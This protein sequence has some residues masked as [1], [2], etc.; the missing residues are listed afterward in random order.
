MKKFFQNVPVLLLTILLTGIIQLNAQT[1]NQVIEFCTG[2]W[3]QWCP[4]GDITI[5]NLL[6]DHPNLIPLAY[7]G[8][9]GSDPY[10]NFP[11]NEIISLLGFTGYPTG[12]VDRVSSPG[13]YTTWT[14]K[15]NSRANIP[16][17][18]SIELQRSYNQA[19]GHLDATIDMTA[20][21]N[22]SGTF[23]YNIILTED[24][25]I[26]DQV[27]NGVCVGGGNDW[28]H[29]WVVRAMINGSSG[30]VIVDN[31]DWNSGEIITKQVTYDVP[32]TF[33]A[34]QCHLVVFVY[35]QNSP[36][37]MAEIQQAEKWSLISPNYVV[38]LV[39]PGSDLIVNNSSSADFT[40]LIR[41]DGLLDDSYYIDIEMSSP[42]G[43]TGEYTTP[44]GTLPFG[45]QD[46]VFVSAGDSLTVDLS[47]FPNSI[48]GFGEV[49]VKF[50]SMND[51]NVFAVQRFR[52][53][54]ESG[55]AGLVIDASAAGY[56]ELLLNI[57]DQ[58]FDYPYGIVSREALN[59]S[60]D[61]TNFT[62]I[63][64]SSGNQYPVLT[65]DEVNALIPFLENGGRLLI[66]GQ[67]IGQDIFDPAGLSQA[68]QS[69]YNNYLHANYVSGWG[70]S[71][72]LNGIAGDPISNQI[73]FPLGDVYPKDPDEFIPMDA[74]ATSLFKFG[75][76]DRFNS[77]KAD[78]GINRVVYFGFGFEQ[79]GDQSI[80][81]TLIAR[82]LRW[83][84]EGVVVSTP[85]DEIKLNTFNLYQNYP[86]PF[87]PATTIQYSVGETEF[88][89]IS[90]YDLLGN[91]IANLVNEVKQPGTYNLTFDASELSSGLY[92]YKLTAGDFVSVKKMT[93]LK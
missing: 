60:V 12:T 87:N 39:S 26:Y 41:N 78:D 77:I 93:L 43:W 85:E 50:T 92:F 1:R 44:N 65:E 28:I 61:L 21:V 73:S 4:C 37:Y 57:L 62:L 53:V 23:K 46:L 5:E 18:V 7:H 45:Q 47:V 35:K 75:I 17:T 3:C 10:A 54:T 34:E 80:R 16:P 90:V 64:W 83:L 69:F 31:S 74:S 81:D 14:G 52:I 55:V 11:G 51:S 76:F 59:P 29:N 72:F 30:E 58:E 9:V 32:L 86:N 91:Q 84:T 25:L 27:N 71:Y 33:D 19:T 82:S 70:N 56:G 2:T 6:D 48:S 67:N 49:T 66:N 68:A 79:I 24:S 40:A 13:D 8:P 36:L 15:F 88:V 63:C 38:T 22:L 42:D 89:S 20:L